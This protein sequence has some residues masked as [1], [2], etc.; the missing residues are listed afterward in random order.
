MAA[1]RTWW[2]WQKKTVD[3][4]LAARGLP[5]LNEE[6]FGQV[7]TRKQSAKKAASMIAR[8]RQEAREKPGKETWRG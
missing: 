2:R 5:P 7:L 3:D 6:E 1:V 8:A 4:E